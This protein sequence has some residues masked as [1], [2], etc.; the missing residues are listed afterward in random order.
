MKPDVCPQCGTE[1][2]AGSL[3]CPECGSC[4]KTGWSE[5][6]RE[7]S[8]DLP[9]THFSYDE[10]VE[11]EFGESREPPRH[12]RRAG[13]IVVTTVL[14]LAVLGWAYLRR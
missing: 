14:L 3:S 6:A 7:Q 13:W 1:I 4:E 8:L 2:P 12:S 5:Q 11:Q 9:D 10:Y